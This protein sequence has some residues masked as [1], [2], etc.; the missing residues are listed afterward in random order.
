MPKRILIVDDEASIRRSLSRYFRLQDYEPVAVA[1]V[2]E[3]L[4]EI[5]TGQIA[6]ALV[7]LQL[8][9]GVLSGM[10]LV[11]YLQRTQPPTPAFVITGTVPLDMRN[12]LEALG[13]SV[14]DKPIALEALTAAIQKALES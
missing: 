7:D 3:A 1:T 4:A 6:A 2:K 8:E 9:P 5:D 11:R 12:D 10:D 13:I 14:F